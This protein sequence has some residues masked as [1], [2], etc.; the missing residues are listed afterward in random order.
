MIGIECCRPRARESERGTTR[1]REG[2]ESRRTLVKRSSLSLR[3]MVFNVSEPFWC[4]VCVA[5][6]GGY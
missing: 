6:W 2:G 3:S 5:A 1:A 4:G